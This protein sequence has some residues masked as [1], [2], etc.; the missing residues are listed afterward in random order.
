M[1][2]LILALII[3]YFLV[4]ILYANHLANLD[5]LD[6]EKRG[7]S[8][9]S[10]SNEDDG[11]AYLIWFFAWPL[12]F[13]SRIISSLIQTAPPLEPRK[14]DI[15]MQPLNLE[16][17]NT[18][19]TW[20]SALLGKI[21]IADGNISEREKIV[22]EHWLLATNET[23]PNAARTAFFS[24]ANNGKNDV[25]ALCQKMASF[26]LQ[27][28]FESIREVYFNDV[29][30][31]MGTMIAAS[32]FSKEE[33]WEIQRAWMIAHGFNEARIR[34]ARSALEGI[35]VRANLDYE[36]IRRYT[37][38]ICMWIVALLAKMAKADGA[39]S[40]EE[41][42]VAQ[43]FI[44]FF[45]RNKEDQ[46]KAQSIFNL[47]KDDGYS[48]QLSAKAVIQRIKNYNDADTIEKVR[49]SATYGLGKMVRADGNFA[50]KAVVISVWFSELGLNPEEVDA[51]IRHLKSKTENTE[52]TDLLHHLSVLGCTETDALGTIKARYR[53]L[54]KELHPDKLTGD[55]MGKELIRV[56]QIRL[57]EINASYKY[58]LNKL[59]SK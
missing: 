58:L 27:S 56:A 41:I 17:G 44:V 9:R 54:A 18:L 3:K 20:T 22:L 16:Y 36:M 7:V 21:A 32:F 40:K 37:D 55:K 31:S 10:S 26:S 19:S 12:I 45:N 57:A 38:D 46:K 47:A 1:I 13:A 43:D 39:I 52:R 48:F 6:R 35:E 33:K 28:K 4:G 5:N 53:E 59:S 23:D 11:G 29:I 30:Q 8:L 51:A 42:S 49:N 25:D 2:F 15:P 50:K 24:G 14:M 34:S